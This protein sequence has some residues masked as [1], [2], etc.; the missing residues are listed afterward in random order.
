[1]K[2]MREIVAVCLML[3][4]FSVQAQEVTILD[5]IEKDVVGEGTVRIYQ[6][7]RLKSAVGRTRSYMSTLHGGESISKVAGYRVQVFAG[8]NSQKARNEAHRIE[9]EVKSLFPEFAVYTQFVSPRW[10]C[11]VGDY[12]TIEEA[13]AV[14]RQLRAT[15]K[16]KEISIVK[17]VV[18]L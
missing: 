18:Y 10:L 5:R 9:E 17:S 15:G 16:F 4:A 2:L 8:N 3:M 13:D 1:M 7:P 11:R 12:K 6:D 14:M